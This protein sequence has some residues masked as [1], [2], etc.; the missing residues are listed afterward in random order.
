MP[1]P[2]RYRGFPT[3]WQR[4]W[5]SI[6]LRLSSWNDNRSRITSQPGAPQPRAR[7]HHAPV[8]SG[9][10][11]PNGGA[12]SR[13]TGRNSQT[14]RRFSQTLGFSVNVASAIKVDGGNIAACRVV[15]GGV[16][17]EPRFLQVVEDVVKGGPQD[18][19]NATLAGET[20]SHGAR[21]VTYNQYKVPILESFV[22]HAVRDA[23]QE[24]QARLD[25]RRSTGPA[26]PAILR[27]HGASATG[28][29]VPPTPTYGACHAPLNFIQVTAAH[30]SFERRS[31]VTP[32]AGRSSSS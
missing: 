19:D 14:Y 28:L 32:N 21:P 4:S 22:K 6:A 15:C 3:C 8:G 24:K 20:A 2:H 18:E 12:S 31:S 27:Y 9:P 7:E 10:K 11:K 26:D 30:R 25:P 16:S 17:A 5:T 23:V 1:H 29:P 13:A